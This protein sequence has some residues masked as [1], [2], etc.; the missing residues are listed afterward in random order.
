MKNKKFKVN[1]QMFAEPTTAGQI[2]STNQFIS[3]DITEEL[4]LV[5][6]NISPIMSHI[7]RGGRIEK[8]NSTTIEWTDHYERKT[9]SKLKVALEPGDA[10]IQVVDADVLVEKA[11]LSIG[12]ELVKIVKVKADNKADIKRAYMNSDKTPGTIAAG[13]PVQSLGIE[14]EEGGDLVPST[15]K[16]PVHIK[17]TT[18]II[19]ESY[20]VTET[21]KHLDIHAQ[22]GLSARE[23][24][25]QKKKDE[26]MGNMENKLINGIQFSAGKQRSSGGIKYLIKKHGIVFDAQNRPI[27]T[28]LL[29]EIV[30]VIVEKG[31]PGA[32][33]LKSGRYNI[34]A[35][36][37]LQT[38]INALNKDTNTSD[39]KDKVTGTVIREAITNA[40]ALSVMPVNSLYPDEFLILNLSELKIKQLYAIKEEVG[41]KTRLADEYFMHGEYAHQLKKLPF[42]VWVKNVKVD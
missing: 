11:V 30:A 23:L 6:P 4:S 40:G 27:S 18:G 37:K 38:Q 8:T 3:N 21:A 5:N 2:N 10:E 36:W 22:G 19:Y 33:D 28:A 34:C 15:V 1:I 32:A 14:M 16:L 12:E 29:D 26:M 7:I 35:P 17:N 41:A 13:T 24:E 9:S 20:E 39:I 31:N 25:S 42:Q